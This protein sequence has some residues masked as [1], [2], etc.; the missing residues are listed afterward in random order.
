MKRSTVA[1]LERL[2]QSEAEPLTPEQYQEQ[3]L[4]RMWARIERTKIERR[5]AW[6]P[7]ITLGQLV[8]LGAALADGRLVLNVRADHSPTW[9]D[10]C[11]PP[12]YPTDCWQ[13]PWYLAGRA[14]SK[15][16][17]SYAT[18]FF[19]DWRGDLPTEAA[20]VLQWLRECVAWFEAP[21]NRP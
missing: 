1:K 13:T 3:L 15:V 11:P 7:A 12:P 18:T 9:Y 4:E 19:D 2:E 17:A 21:A 6:R 20:D 14:A 16:L 10:F 8:E 5:E